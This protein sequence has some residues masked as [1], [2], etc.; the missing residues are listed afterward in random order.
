MVL[1]YRGIGVFFF[2]HFALVFT[3]F[4]FF[5]LTSR[6]KRDFAPCTRPRLMEEIERQ[7]SRIITQS[8]RIAHAWRGVFFFFSSLSIFFLSAI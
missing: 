7:I 2:L 3:G 4:G 5:S 6:S 8:K 1:Q